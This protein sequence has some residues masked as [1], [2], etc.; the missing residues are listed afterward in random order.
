MNFYDHIQELNNQLKSNQITV[1]QFFH[2][3]NINKYFKKLPLSDE[4]IIFQFNAIGDSILVSSFIREVKQ[5][6][7]SKKITL[8]CNDTSKDLFEYC[9][10]IDKLV[11]IK[12]VNKTLPDIIQDL[13]NTFKDNFWKY[14]FALALCPQWGRPNFAASVG[15]NVNS[16]KTCYLNPPKFYDDPIDYDC[17]LTDNLYAPNNIIHNIDRKKY[18]L[19]Y[20]QYQVNSMDLEAWLDDK[21]IIPLNKDKKIII[22]GLGGSLKSKRYP[23]NLLLQALMEINS[24]NIEF[25]ILGDKNDI[26][27][28]NF[29]LANLPNVK[30][31]VNKT[32]LRQSLSLVS[33]CDLY[34]G[35]DTAVAHM[36]SIYHIPTIVLNMESKDKYNDCP[37]HLSSVRQ[38]YPYNT[39]QIIIQP[40]HALEICQ[41]AHIHGGCYYDFPH[42]IT[43]IKPKEIVKAFYEIEG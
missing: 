8:V 42:C 27:V 2:K 22:L 13:I 5:N 7:L 9:P 16:W 18:I 26:D 32:T 20:L 21:D 6:N 34:I 1:A 36:A 29:L 24:S 25:L 38:F 14:K 15:Y 11:P 4:I 19:D 17:L 37:G 30:N 10:Y 39:K 43:Q 41:H 3:L 40:E 35:N 31:F 23:V 28:A 33:Q 12:C